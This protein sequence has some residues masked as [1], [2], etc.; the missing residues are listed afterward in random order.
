VSYSARPQSSSSRPRRADLSSCLHSSCVAPAPRSNPDG[1]AFDSVGQMAVT[2]LAKKL[3]L[4]SFAKDQ[5]LS[6]E[7]AEGRA[8]TPD[9]VRAAADGP[10]SVTVTLVKSSTS[11][12]SVGL[13]L[14]AA[15]PSH[16]RQIIS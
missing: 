5:K 14:Q 9:Y 11:Q 13:V 7:L 10:E 8:P 16:L 12:R 2:S 6:G 15:D 1:R 4:G 3:S